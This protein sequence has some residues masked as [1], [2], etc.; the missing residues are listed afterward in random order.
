MNTAKTALTAFCGGLISVAGFL[1][2][3]SRIDIS[4]LTFTIQHRMRQNDVSIDFEA[5]YPGKCVIRDFEDLR[6]SS[7]VYTLPNGSSPCYRENGTLFSNIA[8]NDTSGLF[9]EVLKYS[10]RSLSVS[11]PWYLGKIYIVTPLHLPRWLDLK[12]PRI[13]LI[14]Q[15]DLLPGVDS[16]VIEQYLH[17]I[18]GLSDV[19]IH[20][21]GDFLFLNATHPHDLFTCKGGI[22]SLVFAA[23]LLSQTHSETQLKFWS[24]STISTQMEVAKRWGPSRELYTLKHGPRIYSRR[25]IDR[26]HDIF[27]DFLRQIRHQVYEGED[28]I[29]PQL[30]HHYMIHQGSQELQI[31]FELLSPE[32]WMNYKLI[33]ASSGKHIEE[34]KTQSLSHVFLALEDNYDRVAATSLMAALY[35]HKVEMELPDDVPPDSHPADCN[36]TREVLETYFKKMGISSKVRDLR[37]TVIFLFRTIQRALVTSIGLLILYIFFLIFVQLGGVTIKQPR[38]KA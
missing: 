33:Y 1:L 14:N 11:M 23:D 36:V 24:N 37:E 2:C 29:L 22:R 8:M 27:G 28:M 20:L 6:R 18:P 26:V 16:T 4:G 5:M 25:A 32:M 13:E 34:E 31:D 10:M 38:L 35:P 30:H 15:D 21:K 17:R 19:Y 12:Y 7:I 3:L 9:D